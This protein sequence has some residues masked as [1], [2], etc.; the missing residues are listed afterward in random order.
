MSIEDFLKP[1][2]I[3]WLFDPSEELITMIVS[4]GN[5]GLVPLAT[6]TE[7][8]AATKI[9]GNEKIDLFIIPSDFNETLILYINQWE[10]EKSNSV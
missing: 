6:Y 8:T 10:E 9:I 1:C 2:G 4:C 5:P 3:F 7:W